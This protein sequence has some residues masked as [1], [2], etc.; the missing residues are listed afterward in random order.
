MDECYLKGLGCSMPENPVFL[1]INALEAFLRA[2]GFVT[3]QRPVGMLCVWG[4]EKA[5]G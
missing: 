1:D 3:R 4:E 2:V 5:D